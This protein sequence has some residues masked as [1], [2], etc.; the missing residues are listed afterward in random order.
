MGNMIHRCGVRMNKKA[1]TMRNRRLQRDEE[2][3]LL[4]AALQKMNGAFIAGSVV[5]STRKWCAAKRKTTQ[6]SRLQ[7]PPRRR[8]LIP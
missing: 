2:K 8:N 1:E 7:T 6:R 5:Y 3:Q 4:D